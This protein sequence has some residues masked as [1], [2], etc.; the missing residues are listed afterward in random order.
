MMKEK[1]PTVIEKYYKHKGAEFTEEELK[2]YQENDIEFD[3]ENPPQFENNRDYPVKFKRYFLRLI[4][5]CNG[6]KDLNE[7]DAGDIKHKSKRLPTTFMVG[8]VVSL[9]TTHNKKIVRTSRY[10]EKRFQKTQATKTR[11]FYSDAIDKK[12]I[13]KIFMTN[14][15]QENCRF[16]P[17]TGSLNPHHI[18]DGQPVCDTDK[19]WCEKLG[20]NLMK[21]HP[22]IYMRG[23]LERAK[24]LYRQGETVKATN[25][26]LETFL[27]DQ[28]TQAGL[29]ET[30]EETKKRHEKEQVA[31]IKKKE[32]EAREAAE[33]KRREEELARRKASR[34]SNSPNRKYGRGKDTIEEKKN[35]DD[36][37]DGLKIENMEETPEEK[38]KN[39]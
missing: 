14:D 34:T 24:R 15:E 1:H 12:A 20:P 8:G 7:L 27:I 13:P 29:K 37:L 26:I 3:D 22:E 32:K 30:K 2:R 38:Q 17:I 25:E 21:L 9:K 19:A 36:D 23:K 16:E 31:A 4:K 39:L 18:D 11:V 28:M 33:K 10:N 35:E 6:K 5:S